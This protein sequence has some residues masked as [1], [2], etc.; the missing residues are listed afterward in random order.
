M[1]V[2][3][4]VDGHLVRTP[5]GKVWSAKI[6][7]Y[8]FFSR[9]L[10]VFE[11][12]KIATRINNVDNNDGYPNLCSGEGI[13]FFDVDE[14]RG[15]KEYARKYLSIKKKIKKSFLDCD[16]A[17]FR[18][19]S[20]IGYQ[21]YSEFK[22]TN[23]PYAVEVVVD[24]WDFAAP[25]MLNTPLRPLIRI[26]WT[27]KLKRICKKANGVSYVTKVALQNRY[28]CRAILSGENEKYFTSHYSSANIDDNFFGKP[29]KFDSI[30]KKVKIVHITNNIGNYVKG[31]KE[32]IEAVAL[33][34]KDNIYPE[35][36]FVGEG[37]LIPEFIKLAE[38]NGVKEQ[39]KFIGKLSDSN[40]IKEVLE[41]NDMFVFP[42]HAEGLPRV[43]IEAM[44]VGLPAISTNIN[45]IPELLKPEYLVEVGTIIPLAEKIKKFVLNPKIMEEESESN[46]R[47][48][49]EYSERNL[50]LRRSVFYNK[51]KNICSK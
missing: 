3:V 25:G 6:Y 23:K 48:A 40:Q 35:I 20:T 50:Q 47:I 21:F 27:T 19:P 46:I 5:D 14:F 38:K 44:A 41:K 33:L 22:K 37:N 30:N 36:T 26:I 8:N 4:V 9:Y 49:K 17:I 7:N 15:P 31:H 11:K 18:I 39:I 28:P 2:L 13:E 51:L 29:K 34:K 43:L 45:G 32:L 42:S 1:R 10:S 24:P 16:C 12:V